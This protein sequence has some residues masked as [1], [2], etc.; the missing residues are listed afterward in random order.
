MNPQTERPIINNS[1]M[2]LL[3][4]HREGRCLAECSEELERLVEAVRLTRKKGT[5]HLELV[6][7]PA[8]RGAEVQTVIIR[9][10]VTC[11]RPRCD[12][13]E[14]IFFATDGNQLSR[15]NPKQMEMDLRVIHPPTP[16]Q[17]EAAVY[18]QAAS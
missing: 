5:F 12:R 7:Q 2:R 10:D 1:F 6:I 13:A 15:H 11:K 14:S 9:D 8:N 4:D 3:T 17:P 18:N 16:N